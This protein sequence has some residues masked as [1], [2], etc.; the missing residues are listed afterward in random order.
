MSLVRYS[1]A[2]GRAKTGDYVSMFLSVCNAANSVL[3]NGEMPESLS[4]CSG[5]FSRAA[6][7]SNFGTNCR[8]SL[9]CP[10]KSFKSVKDKSDWIL[11]MISV[12]CNAIY[13]RLG[14]KKKFNLCDCFDAGRNILSV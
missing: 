13:R 8:N 6:I 2:S 14:Q 3:S 4:F 12:V 5:L 9:H 1:F 7:L 11:S 10:G